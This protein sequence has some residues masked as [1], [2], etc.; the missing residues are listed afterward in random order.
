[1]ANV[2]D[3]TNVIISTIRRHQLIKRRIQLFEKKFKSNLKSLRKKQQWIVYYKKKIN[4]RLRKQLTQRKRIY[5]IKASLFQYS[6]LSTTIM[7]SFF[8][9]ASSWTQKLIFIFIIISTKQQ[10][11][12]NW[13]YLKS[14]S[15]QTVDKSQLLNIETSPS[16]SRF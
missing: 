5:N 14:A 11:Q 10:N 15:H 12:S 7:S 4:K 8:V 13:F 16:K 2:I 1:V 9:R 3:I 6:Q